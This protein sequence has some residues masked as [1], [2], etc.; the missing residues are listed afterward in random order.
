MTY[1]KPK[2]QL[3]SI[4][5]DNLAH[6]SKLFAMRAITHE[7]LPPH[8]EFEMWFWAAAHELIKPKNYEMPKK[9][10]LDDSSL[11]DPIKIY[12]ALKTNLEQRPYAGGLTWQL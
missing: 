6:I 7:M 12:E 10:K 9:M 3:A 1:Q 11:S 8:W 4:S 5:I 2:G